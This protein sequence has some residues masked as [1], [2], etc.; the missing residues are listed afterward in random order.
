MKRYFQPADGSKDNNLKL[1]NIEDKRGNIHSK[2]KSGPVFSI[3]TEVRQENMFY[4]P[5]KAVQMQTQSL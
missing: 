2:L 3:W 4:S 1:L 5:N